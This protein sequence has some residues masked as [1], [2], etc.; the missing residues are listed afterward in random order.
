[1]SYQNGKTSKIG[2]KLRDF[3][4]EVKKN[5]QRA[6]IDPLLPYVVRDIGANRF[7][8]SEEYDA[9]GQ[10]EQRKQWLER[11]VAMI[12]Q[13]DSPKEP[14]WE[15]TWE[16]YAQ[17]LNGT[18]GNFSDHVAKLNHTPKPHAVRITE[19][20]DGCGLTLVEYAAKQ[21]EAKLPK[22]SIPTPKF[23]TERQRE[24][25]MDDLEHGELSNFIRKIKP[26]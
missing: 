17:V 18:V 24:T 21:A 22:E 6:L 5:S 26:S 19:R 15:F 23:V 7:Y 1:M 20:P 13:G 14:G 2:P 10:L 11:N 8:I 9:A 4:D 25:I 3:F 12:S 16:P